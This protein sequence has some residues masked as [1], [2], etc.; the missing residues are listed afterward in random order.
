MLTIVLSGP[1][2]TASQART[3]LAGSGFQP[4]ASDHDHGLPATVTGAKV[5]QAQAFVTVQGD[6]VNAAH[7]AV[8]PLGWVLRAH[9]ETPREQV[10]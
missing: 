5:R 8:S 4:D 9:W 10:E 1:K 2:S 6:D 7:S 3:A